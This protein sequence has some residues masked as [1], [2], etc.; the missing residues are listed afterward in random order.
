MITSRNPF[1]N[2]EKNYLRRILKEKDLSIKNELEKYTAQ[3]QTQQQTQ[4]QEHFLLFKS[5][6]ERWSKITIITT[7][8]RFFKRW[9]D[10]DDSARRLFRV[11]SSCAK[12]PTIVA[13]KFL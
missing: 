2:W 4:Q 8:P 10:Y 3:Q 7:A 6:Q 12:R 11:V 1:K 13:T 5:I 9:W